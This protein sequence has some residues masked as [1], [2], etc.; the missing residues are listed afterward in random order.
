MMMVTCPTGVGPGSQL[1]VHGP[2]G[3]PA[4][5]TVPA[6]VMPGQT[7]QVILPAPSPIVL[8]QPIAAAAPVPAAQPME[9]EQLDLPVARPV[10]PRVV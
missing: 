1:Q 8:A 5:V 9:I 6:G 10:A 2:S 4:L 7:F 3:L